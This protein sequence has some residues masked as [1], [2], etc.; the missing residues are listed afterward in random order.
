MTVSTLDAPRLQ[1]EYPESDGKPM[2]ETPAHRQA[3]NDTIEI[4]IDFFRNNPTVYV[5]GNM[6]LYYEEGEPSESVAPDVFVVKGVSKTERRVYKLWEEN[7]PPTVVFEFTSRA[8][9]LDDVGN[10]KALY[11]LLGAR[12]YFIC[13]PLAEYL[14]PP[15]QGFSLE[16]GEYRRLPVESDD[17]LVSQELGLRL[18]LENSRLRLSVVATGEPLLTP[19]EALEKARAAAAEIESLK[20]ELAHLRGEQ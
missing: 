20:A 14:S 6:M 15:L 4:L 13:D 1:I 17:S 7:R 2:A 16:R 9:R 10:K 3:L 8:T 5:S 12:E 19:A 11:A 18:K